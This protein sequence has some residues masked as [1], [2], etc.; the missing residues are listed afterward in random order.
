MVASSQESFD[1]YVYKNRNRSIQHVI[2]LRPEDVFEENLQGVEIADKE[3]YNW[4]DT[5]GS[6]KAV[7]NEG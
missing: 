3:D 4:R 6:A 5:Y 7:I 1:D 2:L